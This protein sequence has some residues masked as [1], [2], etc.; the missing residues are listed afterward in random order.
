MAITAAGDAPARS[1]P[2][3]SVGNRTEDE[4]KMVAKASRKLRLTE[5]EPAEFRLRASEQ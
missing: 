5:N 2:G 4:R 1:Q 3:P